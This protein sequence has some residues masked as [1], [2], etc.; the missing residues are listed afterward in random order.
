MLIR[1][2]LMCPGSSVP[3]WALDP[4][5]IGGDLRSLPM[6]F[7]GLTIVNT[8]APFFKGKFFHGFSRNFKGY[9]REFL[10][11]NKKL[12]LEKKVFVWRSLEGIK[13]KDV[14]DRVGGAMKYNDLR[15]IKY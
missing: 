9:P 7:L 2:F 1:K 13:R 10:L 3:K 15:K 5:H 14:R 6:L 8:S 12:Y 11:S 4:E